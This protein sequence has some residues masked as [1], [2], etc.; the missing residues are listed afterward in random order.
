VD[1]QAK[2]VVIRLPRVLAPM[3][4]GIREFR[5]HGRNIAEALA[6]LVQ[7]RPDLERHLFDESGDLRRHVRCFCD[8]RYA[9]DREGLDRPVQGGETITILHSVSG[10]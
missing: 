5:V 7:L 4:S 6:D 9:S 10:G 2:E 8:A 1:S 3:A